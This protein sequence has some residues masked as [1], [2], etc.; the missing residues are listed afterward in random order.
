ME[1]KDLRKKIDEIDAE[2]IDVL[3]RRAHVVTAIGTCK[4][5]LG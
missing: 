1:L 2:L 4:N 5:S 3:A